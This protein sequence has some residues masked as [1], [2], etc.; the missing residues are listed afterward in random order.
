[1]EDEFIFCFD[2][3]YCHWRIHG[4]WTSARIRYRQGQSHDRQGYR[5]RN[6]RQRNNHPCYVFNQSSGNL[7]FETISITVSTVIPSSSSTR[8]STALFLTVSSKPECTRVRRNLQELDDRNKPR[9]QSLL[10]PG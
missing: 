7:L 3:E 8:K 4:R 9:L 1:M 2:P 10:L 5:E 6:P